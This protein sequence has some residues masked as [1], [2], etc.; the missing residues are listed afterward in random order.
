MFGAILTGFSIAVKAIT[1]AVATIGPAVSSF[2]TKVAPL[3]TTA[4]S[5]APALLSRVSDFASVFLGLTN[6]FKQGEKVDEIGEAS[7]QAADKGITPDQFDD[8]DEYMEELR[9]YPIDPKTAAAR[10]PIEKT[11]AGMAIGSV[12]LERRYN[13]N[14]GDFKDVWLLP[15]AHPD[16]FT[17][18]R[19]K[20]IVSQG[21]LTYSLYDYLNSNLSGS[22][23]R[24][25]EKDLVSRLEIDNHDDE[26][27]GQLYETLDEA[28][29]N[30]QEFYK[31]MKEES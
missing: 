12:G 10:S 1:T 2:A 6:V 4:L 5:K 16:Y 13:A 23:A 18:E 31:I 14:P 24:T 19:M 25:L 28:K 29:D 26:S 20:S 27:I 11:V 17:S 30:V 7:L 8:F 21:R 15:L 22:Q 3:I 9:N